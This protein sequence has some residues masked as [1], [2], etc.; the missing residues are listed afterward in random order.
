MITQA[1][2]SAFRG[3]FLHVEGNAR[4]D[5]KGIPNHRVDVFLAPAGMGGQN[6]I[7]L[8]AAVTR[9]DGTF[10]ADVPV[11][12]TLD[13]ARYEILLSFAGDAYYNDALSE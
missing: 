12:G 11:P 7:P 1:Q 6:S 2:D 13:L 4:V 8:G 10:S 5:G 3:D 9:D